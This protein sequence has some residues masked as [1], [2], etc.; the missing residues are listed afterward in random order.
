MADQ[1]IETI[2]GDNLIKMLQEWIHSRRLCKMEIPHTNYGWI[3]LLLALQQYGDSVYLMIDKVTNF[4]KALSRSPNQEVSIE[5][6]EKD[7]VTCQFK[8]RVIECFPKILKAE[9]PEG[10]YRIQ[11]RR[12]FRV[13]ARSGTEIVFDINQAKGEKGKVKDYSLGGAAFFAE[14]LLDIH[15]GDQL[16]KIDLRVPQGEEWIC[17]H[18]PRALV[19]R[20]EKQSKGKNVYALEFFE[21]PEAT[22]RLL[23]HH[24]FE[25]ERALLRKTKR[26]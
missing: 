21:M 24:L 22:T 3:T 4:E 9:L 6:L 10:I 17:F 15:I 18:I 8:T 7:G 23:W 1:S 14:D 13:Q 5:F 19:K 26:V 20:I 2:T 11:R 25:E 12:F 16:D